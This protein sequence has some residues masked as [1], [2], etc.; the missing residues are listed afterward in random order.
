MCGWLENGK[1][2]DFCPEAYEY[3]KNNQAPPRP[4]D[5]KEQAK[6]SHLD[7]KRMFGGG[8]ITDKDIEQAE[9]IIKQRE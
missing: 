9:K 8:E 4:D 6:K 7:W 3:D 5:W 2:C 1:E